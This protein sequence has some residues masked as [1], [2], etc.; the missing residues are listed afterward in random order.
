MGIV[1]LVVFALATIST[2]TA[3]TV[4]IDAN[5]NMVLDAGE[6]SGTKIQ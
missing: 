3:Q 1:L 4:F 5:K 6:W 2:A